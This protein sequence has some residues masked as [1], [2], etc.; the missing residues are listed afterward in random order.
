VPNVLVGHSSAS[1]DLQLFA[2]R[3]LDQV[4]GMVL[5]EPSVEFQDQ[6]FNKI[7]PG[8]AEKIAEDLA[9]ARRCLTE[10]KADALKLGSHHYAA[11]I[12]RPTPSLPDSLNA[13]ELKRQ[14][15]VSY[16]E[17]VLSE[18]ESLFGES[19]R[20][21]AAARRSYGNMPLIVLTAGDNFKLDAGK[22]DSAAAARRA[23]WM[24]MHDELA[25][26]STVGVNRMVE[27][28]RHSIQTSKPEAVI[29]AVEE[30]VDALAIKQ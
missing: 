22:P 17:T 19:S 15:S 16:E 9:D 1:L 25:A 4:V 10:L 5:V 30:V 23:L 24:T 18:Y 26:L 2:D 20:E 27:G 12:A 3:H 29:Q 13:L 8:R 14:L 21:V 11:C 28:A 6:R 7:S